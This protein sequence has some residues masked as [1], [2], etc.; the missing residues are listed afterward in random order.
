[1][2]RKK[3]IDIPL[4]LVELESEN[5]HIVVESVFPNE[6]KGIWIVDTGASKSVF[7]KNLS[8]LFQP[9]SLDF[10][11]IQ[12]AG[13]SEHQIETLPG[14]IPSL[15]FGDLQLTDFTVALIDLNHVNN[16]YSKVSNYKIIGLLGSDVLVKYKAV[17]SYKKLLLRVYA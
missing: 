1:M 8:H 7:D 2:P 13:I 9:L 3:K 16:I 5:Y 4:L 6:E 14:L 11:E 17:I 10:A 15:K 12:S